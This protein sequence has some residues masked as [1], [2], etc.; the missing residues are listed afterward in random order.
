MGK[1]RAAG[2][3]LLSVFYVSKGRPLCQVSGLLLVLLLFL[4]SLNPHLTP[5]CQSNCEMDKGFLFLS[6]HRVVNVVVFMLKRS[7]S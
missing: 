7:F 3:F 4:F 6:S 5:C 1:G 2:M